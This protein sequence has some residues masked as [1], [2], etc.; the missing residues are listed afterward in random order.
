M[1]KFLHLTKGDHSSSKDACSSFIGKVYTLGKLHLTVEDTIA[2]GGFALVFLV[3]A[4][5]GTHYAL[6]RMYVNNEYD[7]HV[8]R[9]E[10]KIVVSLSHPPTFNCHRITIKSLA[11]LFERIFS[12][13]L[14]TCAG[15]LNAHH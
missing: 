9:R 12:L 15:I 13:S 1:K 10:I 11:S 2:E 4:A 8:C 14:S 5:N 6:K 7:L 3:R